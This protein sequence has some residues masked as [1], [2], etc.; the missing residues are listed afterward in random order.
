VPG[1]EHGGRAPYLHERRWFLSL[2]AMTL[3]MASVIGYVPIFDGRGGFQ[4]VGEGVAAMVAYDTALPALLAVLILAF[5]A[6][7]ARWS[8]RQHLPPAMPPDLPPRRFLLVWTAVAAATLV[9][10]PVLASY[11]FAL[12]LAPSYF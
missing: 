9:A 4:S 2:I 10:L 6:V 11:G 12:C 3:T 5:S 8:C 1:N 7:F